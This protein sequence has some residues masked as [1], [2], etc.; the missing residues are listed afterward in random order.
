MEAVLY[1]IKDPSNLRL[2]EAAFWNSL[3][4]L[5]LGSQLEGAYEHCMLSP[6]L[7]R[8]CT[9]C[10]LSHRI[11]LIHPKNSSSPDLSSQFHATSHTN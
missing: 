10:S 6:S 5:S 9:H 7:P 3:P 1:E 2:S 4:N 11:L 8:N